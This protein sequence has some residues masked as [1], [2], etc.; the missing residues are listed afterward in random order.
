GTMTN[1]APQDWCIQNGACTANLKCLTSA[2]QECHT[3]LDEHRVDPWEPDMGWVMMSERE[4]NRV[5]VLSQ[6]LQG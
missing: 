2:V 5:E 1:P 4:L 3:P 6:V